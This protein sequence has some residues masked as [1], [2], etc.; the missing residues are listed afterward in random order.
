MALKLYSKNIPDNIIAQLIKNNVISQD[1]KVKAVY[2][3]TFLGKVYNAS[4]I[5]SHELINWSKKGKENEK[6]VIDLNEVK[7]ITL[8]EEGI[9]GVIYYVLPKNKALSLK[10]L[11]RDWEKFYKISLKY[12]KLLKKNS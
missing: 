2:V 5:T 9:Y 11:R 7:D 8:G 1:H 4:I 6:I 10:I 3:K 12:W